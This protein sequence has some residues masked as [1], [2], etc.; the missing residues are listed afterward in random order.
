[1]NKKELV[2][3]IAQLAGITQAQAQKVL[4]VTTGVIITNVKKGEPVNLV[5]FV[6]FNV[7]KRAERTGRYPMT[8]ATIKIKAAKVLRFKPGSKLRKAV[9]GGTTNT[10]PRVANK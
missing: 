2:R 5:G 3:E 9:A 10:G 8:G 6:S 1:M 4:D 7:G